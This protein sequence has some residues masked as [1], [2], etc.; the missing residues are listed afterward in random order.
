MMMIKII[1]MMIDR[2]NNN[3]R[4]KYRDKQININNKNIH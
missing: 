3:N 4:D 1:M 2:Y